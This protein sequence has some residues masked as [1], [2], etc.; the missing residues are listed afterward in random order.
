MC[1]IITPAV[2]SIEERYESH[3]ECA[4]RRARTS[5]AGGVVES[6]TNLPFG[7]G[8]SCTG[9]DISPLHFTGKMRDTETNLDDFGARYFNSGMGRWVTPDWSAIPAPVPYANLTNPQTLN[10]YQYVEDDP[11]TFADLDGHAGSQE[12]GQNNDQ[13]A[14]T[15][16]TTCRSGLTGGSPG[17]ACTTTTTSGGQAQQQNSST[18]V[19]EQVKGEG[20]NALG[21]VAIGINGATPVGLVPDSDKTAI[22]ALVKEVASAANGTPEAS[23]VPGHVESLA[24]NRAIK[25]KA[26]IHVTPQ[27][28]AAMQAAI[29][30]M[31]GHQMYDPAYRNCASFVEEVLR[32]GGV[33]APSDI[34]PGG[35]VGDLNKQFPQ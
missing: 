11:E 25:A 7:D 16:E 23:P 4:T 29:K 14:S 2:M 27:Q 26:T 1:G 19:V 8:Q 9:S 35:L 13:S 6:C 15:S 12:N 18:V 28:A 24:A 10:L 30:G 32:S 20:G 5:V 17:S 31:A 33:K 21:H 3:K 22:K 34:T